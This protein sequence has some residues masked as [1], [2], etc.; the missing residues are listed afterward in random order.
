MEGIPGVSAGLAEVLLGHF[1]SI[2][3]LASVP[4]SKGLKASKTALPFLAETMV[5]EQPNFGQPP[6]EHGLSQ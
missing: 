1:G 5:V 6:T 3:N 2:A 4:R